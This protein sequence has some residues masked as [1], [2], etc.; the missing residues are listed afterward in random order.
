MRIGLTPPTL[1]RPPQA[2]KKAKKKRK[3]E[4]EDGEPEKKKKKKDKKCVNSCDARRVAPLA[5]FHRCCCRRL[6]LRSTTR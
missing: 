5:R 2:E 6:C 1:L 3:S 4:A